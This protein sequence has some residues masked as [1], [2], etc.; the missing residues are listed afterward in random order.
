MRTI[1]GRA[2]V[3]LATAL[4]VAFIAGVVVGAIAMSRT[5]GRGPSSSSA[6]RSPCP[7]CR[8]GCGPRSWWRGWHLAATPRSPALWCGLA[9]AG[10]LS[11]LLVVVGDVRW[12]V[13]AWGLGILAVLLL[14][15]TIRGDSDIVVVLVAL[16]LSFAGS[17]ARPA[18]SGDDTIR[19]VRPGDEYLAAMGDDTCRERARRRSTRDERTRFEPVSSGAHRVHASSRG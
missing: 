14:L 16:A 6:C 8:S 10:V 4:A 2:R 3:V 17:A 19:Q 15:I 7:L 13:L 9:V 11:V 18:A 1:Q 12:T 5:V